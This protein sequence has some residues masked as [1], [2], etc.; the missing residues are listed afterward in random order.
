MQKHCMRL[1]RPGKDDSEN[2]V[3]KQ[4]STEAAKRY[5]RPSRGVQQVQAED[6]NLAIGGLLSMI[7]P[8]SDTVR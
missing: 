3:S 6:P 1:H 2:I 4:Q 7:S 8:V 5:G